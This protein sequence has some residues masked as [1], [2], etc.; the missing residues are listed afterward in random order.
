MQV[1]GGRRLQ[2]GDWLLVCSDGLTNQLRPATIEKILLDSPSAE[3]AARRL[4]NRAN[5]EGALDNV[6]VIVVRAV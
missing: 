5:L 4:V 2:P 1:D 3:K 6:S